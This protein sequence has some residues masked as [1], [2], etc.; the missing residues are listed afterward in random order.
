MCQVDVNKGVMLNY[1]YPLNQ[2]ILKVFYN[3]WLR[4]V[5]IRQSTYK[6]RY[7]SGEKP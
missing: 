5:Q 7:N 3:V 4:K 6:Y 1:P 2:K